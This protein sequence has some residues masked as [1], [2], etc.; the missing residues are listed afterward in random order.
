MLPMCQGY[1]GVR[2]NCECGTDPRNNLKRNGRRR[3]RLGVRTAASEE[4]GIAP[5]KAHFSLSL[6]RVLNQL[7]IDLVLRSLPSAPDLASVNA[8]DIRA[9]ISEDVGIDQV[10]V[11]NHIAR[12]DQVTRFDSQQTRVARSCAHKVHGAWLR[13]TLECD[14]LSPLDCGLRGP[15]AR[16]HR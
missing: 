8:F 2:R 7:D 14:D 1:S 16:S 3:E 9:C 11:N 6:R 10:I 13:L 12:G 15:V 5:F 4:K